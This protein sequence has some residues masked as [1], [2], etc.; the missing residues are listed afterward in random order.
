MEKYRLVQEHAR[1]EAAA[2]AMPQ[3]STAV[4]SDPHATTSSSVDE[5]GEL[6][7]LPVVRIT[8]QG[9]PRNYISY[10]MG[11]FVRCCCC[12]SG[13]R[14]FRRLVCSVFPGTRSIHPSISLALTSDLHL[15]LSL[16]VVSLPRQSE[17]ATTIVIKAMGRAIN[18]AVT[19]AEILK[20]KMPLHQLNAL[21]SVE[22]V[23][24]YEPVEEGLDIVTSRRYVSCMTITLSLSDH[25]VDATHPGYQPPLPRDEMSPTPGDYAGGGGGGSGGT[26]AGSGATSSPK[27]SPSIAIM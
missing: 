9:K 7:A 17:G 27:Y 21:S 23:D 1:G 6:G 26:G 24:V 13:D 16:V 3:S 11:L 5:S 22:M 10:A 20:R 19:I 18:K 12:D 25:A 2:A 8:Q 15:R 14:V 4:S